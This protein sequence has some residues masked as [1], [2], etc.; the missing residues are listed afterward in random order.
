MSRPAFNSA[1]LKYYPQ[2]VTGPLKQFDTAEIYYF[3]QTYDFSQPTPSADFCNNHRPFFRQMY[4]FC[5]ESPS[6]TGRIDGSTPSCSQL[7]AD[8][9]IPCVFAAEE[10]SGTH[11]LRRLRSTA[12]LTIAGH[13]AVRVKQRTGHLFLLSDVSHSPCRLK[14]NTADQRFGFCQLPT[15]LLPRVSDVW[16]TSQG[17]KYPGQDCTFLLES[18]F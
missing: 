3:P 13:K 15:F 7:A 8:N 11:K 14:E 2:D 18:S 6:E 17:H 1:I 9:S 4:S 16:P 5:G 10:I 12:P